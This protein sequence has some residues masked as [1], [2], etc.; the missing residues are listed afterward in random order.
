MRCFYV[1]RVMLMPMLILTHLLHISVSVRTYTFVGMVCL[2]FICNYH[3]E[4]YSFSPN[5]YYN[6]DWLVVLCRFLLHIMCL[7]N[8]DRSIQ[9]HNSQRIAL[10]AR[11]NV[12]HQ[13]DV[14][15]CNRLEIM[16]RERLN[17]SNAYTKSQYASHTPN[18]L[19]TD[20]QMVP[21]RS[22]HKRLNILI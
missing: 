12:S 6:V 9:Y 5:I 14:F 15:Q 2:I 21:K 3:N 19:N 20:L 1:S 8:A 10:I 4:G 18:V 22:N 13:P 17:S 16:Q 7:G 11:H